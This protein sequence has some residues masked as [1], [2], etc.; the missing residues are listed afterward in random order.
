MTALAATS[1]ILRA[2][3]TSRLPPAR[4]MALFDGA[5]FC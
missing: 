4:S 2:G 5:L 3:G 1:A